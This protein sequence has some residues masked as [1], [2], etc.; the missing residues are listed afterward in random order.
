MDVI[1][2]AN[3]KGGTGKTTVAVNLSAELASLNR[4][5]LLIDLDSQG[6]CA[7]GLGIKP[8]RERT[9]HKAIVEPDAHL[10]DVVYY[11]GLENLH[12]APADPLFEHSS[13]PKDHLRLKALLSEDTLEERFD[14]VIIDTPPSL[15]YLLLNALFAANWVI[16]PYI[17]HHLSLDGVRR[18]VRVIF[19]IITEHR[20]SIKLL[21][22]LPTMATEHIK[23]HRNVTGTVAKEFGYFRLL[24]PIRNDIRLA[25][26]MSA[27]KPIRYYNPKSRAAQDFSNLALEVLKR[28]N[29]KTA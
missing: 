21:G 15:D 4:R 9:I 19:K 12:L 22:F 27:G 6:H 16:V 2:I 29:Q 24:P 11:T 5:V 7:V 18:L 23:E 3:R 25:E 20:H 8:D 28:L 13:C 1:A 14:I 26:A 10:L 17:P